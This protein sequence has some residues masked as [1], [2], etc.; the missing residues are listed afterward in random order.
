MT[1][2]VTPTEPRMSRLWGHFSWASHYGGGLI[3]EGYA[4]REGGGDDVAADPPILDFAATVIACAGINF[5][6]PASN[7]QVE[8]PPALASSTA[9]R[10][11][12][13]ARRRG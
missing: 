12:L 13:A 7:Y 8:C 1:R 11:D 6:P 9:A 3:I 2:I 4:A 5:I 10:A